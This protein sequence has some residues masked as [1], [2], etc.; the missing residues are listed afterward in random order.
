[1]IK[2]CKKFFDLISTALQNRQDSIDNLIMQK[3]HLLKNFYDTDDELNELKDTLKNKVN[4]I[5]ECKDPELVM[6]EK[7][8]NKYLTE[9]L[10]MLADPEKASFD[11]LIL[12]TLIHPD[13][14]VKKTQESELPDFE[15]FTRKKTRPDY[16][17]TIEIKEP[18]TE[19]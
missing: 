3:Q 15:N 14:Y 8:I 9:F 16:K 13:N 10:N 7:L 12:D 4:T 17:R 1:M 11:N 19:K 2:N 18:L 6:R 5:N